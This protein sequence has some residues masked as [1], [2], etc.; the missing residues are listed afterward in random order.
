MPRMKSRRT[1][2]PKFGGGSICAGGDVDHLADRV[3]QQPELDALAVAQ[4]VEDHDAGLLADAAPG[5]RSARAGRS[6]APPRRA[7]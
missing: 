7:G 3:D 1:A 6:P 4:A 2:A 5:G